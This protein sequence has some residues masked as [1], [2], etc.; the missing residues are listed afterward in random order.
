MEEPIQRDGRVKAAE[1]VAAELQ[2][3]GNYQRIVDAGRTIG[4]DVKTGLV[5]TVYTVIANAARSLITMFPGL[6]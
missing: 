1:A 2:Q 4:V 5:T 6:P 3:G